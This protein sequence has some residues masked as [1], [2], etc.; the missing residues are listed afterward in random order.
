MN[1]YE[2]FRLETAAGI[3]T[4]SINRPRVRNAMDAAFWRE[5][6]EIVR[7]LEGDLAV[8]VLILRGEGPHFCAGIDLEYLHAIAPRGEG[9]RAREAVAFR[10]AILDM[11]AAITSLEDVRFPVIAAIHGACIGAGLDLVT[12]AD[13]RIAS[14]D[15][16]FR[17]EET[18]LGIVA[19]L[20]SLQRLPRI[21]APGAARELALT[22]RTLDAAEAARLGLVTALLPDRSALDTHAQ[23][24]AREIAAKSPLAVAGVK[25]VMNRDQAAA[26][27]EGLD[28][29][30]T[31]NAG[32]LSV[33]DVMAALAAA[34][35][36]RRP[37]FPD[38]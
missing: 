10:R 34:R 19:D 36:R 38:G 9:E 6:P 4:L 27:R 14:E 28:Y 33:D 17:I 5:L 3:A 29:V 2:S 25:A 31:W 37:E 8:R 7:Q 30:A 1:S 35:A 12:A 23:E 11:Q 24:L 22:G 16:E 15:A 13:I 32:Q 18:N 21:I 20:G 26:V